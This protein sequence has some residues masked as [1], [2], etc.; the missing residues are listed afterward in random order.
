MESNPDLTRD[1]VR[2]GHEI[3]NHSYSHPDLRRLT[4]D[5]IREQ[6]DHTEQIARDLT[7][8]S[9]RPFFRPPFGGRDSRVKAVAAEE[10]FRSVFW[11][12]DSWDAFKKG[13]TSAEIRERVLSRVKDGSAFAH[14]GDEVQTA[15]GG[16]CFVTRDRE[17]RLAQVTCA[18]AA[19]SVFWRWALPDGGRIE[20]VGFSIDGS[21]F[22]CHKRTSHAGSETVLR[23]LTPPTSTCY[24]KKAKITYSYPVLA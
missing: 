11:S 17:R 20:S 8:V 23:V 21:S 7:G 2:E 19:I 10:G 15:A 9:T 6:L 24:V 3:G 4:D 12:V 18:N 16:E 14:Y 1:I 22:G 5:Q 13:I